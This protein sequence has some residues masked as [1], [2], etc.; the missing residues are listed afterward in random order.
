MN[1][2]NYTSTPSYTVIVCTGT[3]FFTIGL[4]V[5]G[6]LCPVTETNLQRILPRHLFHPKRKTESDFETLLYK[7]KQ[8]RGKVPNTLIQCIEMCNLE[9]P[10]L[11]V[12]SRRPTTAEHGVA[13]G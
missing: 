13:V 8:R 11:N 4:T 2:S 7:N 3:L 1:E 10:L 12:V 6:S 5:T 9:S